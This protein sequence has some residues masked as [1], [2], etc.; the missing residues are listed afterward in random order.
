M[1]EVDLPLNVVP[2][3]DVVVGDDL[4]VDDPSASSFLSCH[5][6]NERNPPAPEKNGKTRRPR[7]PHVYDTQTYKRTRTKDRH[8]ILRHI[9]KNNETLTIAAV[10]FF[11]SS[12]L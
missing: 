5:K 12:Q 1:G 8:A 9:S 4:K 10:F 2:V 3:E 6:K 11:C 7:L